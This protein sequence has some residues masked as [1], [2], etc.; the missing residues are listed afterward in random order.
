MAAC[1]S[2][3]KSGAICEDN[4]IKLLDGWWYEGRNGFTQSGEEISGETEVFMCLNELACATDVKNITVTCNEGYIGVLCGGC[5]LKEENYMRSGQLCRKCDSFLYNIVFVAGMASI[6]IG[7]ILYV[8]AFQNFSS[9]Q[10]DQRGVVMKIAMSFCQMLTVLG[11]FKARGTALFNEI[12][13]RP[14]SIA[15]GGISSALPLKCLLN[16][17]IYGPF[18]VNMLLPPLA[19]AGAA[20]IMVPTAIVE[21]HI[22]NRRSRSKAPV[23]KGKFNIPRCLAVHKLMRS[24]MTEADKDEWL[25]DFFPVQRLA[26]VGAFLLFFM[27]VANAVSVRGSA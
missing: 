18:I 25:G 4:E 20:L 2:C 12:V 21:R 7:Y 5:N 23:F 3:L 16:S 27:Y 1:L 8:I 26:G 19:L 9:K 14:A 13:Q 10:N 11:V 24:P 6:A 17:Q 22:R 15:G